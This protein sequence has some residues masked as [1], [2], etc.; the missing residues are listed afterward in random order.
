MNPDRRLGR[1][2]GMAFLV[3]FAGSVLSGVLSMSILDGP[4]AEALESIA[5]YP[6]QMRWS[7]LIELCITSVG[8]VVLAALL[9]T[10]CKE[11][12]PLLALVGPWLVVRRSD[13][14]RSQHDRGVP[15]HSRERGIRRSGCLGI[16]S[17]RRAR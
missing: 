1:Y 9:Y 10:V 5:Q 6:A 17:S 14:T 4:T 8:I 2:L 13:H 7:A 11:Q 15:S 16:V 12:N 3:V